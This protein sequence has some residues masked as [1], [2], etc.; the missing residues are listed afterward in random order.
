MS[1]ADNMA[2]I[3][4]VRMFLTG[5]VLAIASFAAYGVYLVVYRLWFHPLRHFPGPKLA[6]ATYWYEVYYEWFHGPY[7][8]LYEWQIRKL[9][10][11]YGPIIR[12]TPD[13]L[14]IQDSDF[15]DVFFAGG[16]RNLWIRGEVANNGATQGTIP[17]DLHKVRRG[18]LTR[19]FSKRS[20][21][22]LEPIV[23]DK[24]EQLCKGIENHVGTDKVLNVNVAFGALT[25][26]VVTDYCF[27]QSFGCLSHPQFAPE[28]RKIF[29]DAFSGIPLLR[30][31]G[32]I[33]ARM[34][35]WPQWI[36]KLVNPEIKQFARLKDDINVKIKE[37]TAQWH[38]DQL[39]GHDPTTDL[40][41]DA[42]SAKRRR[43]I[44][45]H[46]L[47]SPTLSDE[48]KSVQRLGEE[49][50]G[51]VVAGGDTTGRVLANLIYHVHANPQWLQ[52]VRDELSALMPNRDI[53]ASWSELE[54]LPVFSA[55]IRET[56][57]ISSLITERL[58][59]YE[60]EE[61]LTFQGWVLPPKTPIGM[62][63]DEL[64][65]DAKVYD[66]PYVFNPGRWLQEHK[67][68]GVDLNKYYAPFSRGTRNCLGQK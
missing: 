67:E 51:V 68:G 13:E 1:A 14:S 42:S 36:L 27:D 41:K 23:I 64:N 19:F 38:A 47:D 4:P 11:R 28:Y 59:F 37:V 33:V 10:D 50:L 15:F 65:H 2:S 52:Q 8:G 57:R 62:S 32:F 34:L 60:P 30:C 20:V 3:S 21:L 22:L 9:H 46:I 31:W 29:L 40:V 16:R 18:A 56:L 58:T 61:T 43:T 5:A 55:C 53:L 26:D 45:Y 25:L 49:A 66:Q 44:F 39:S 7:H 54:S 63:L 6:A 17:R 35:D 12:R 48:D 24:V